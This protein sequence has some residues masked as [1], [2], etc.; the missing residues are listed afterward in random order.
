MRFR[1]DM[2]VKL[3]ACYGSDELIA[4]A[5]RVSTDGAGSLANRPKRRL[6]DRLLRRRVQVARR[7]GGIFGLINYLLKHRHGSPFEHNGM[8]F[9][10]EAPIFV[11]RELMRHRIGVSYN[12]TSAR[13]RDLE[14]VFYVPAGERGLVRTTSTA[15]PEFASGSA[16]QRLTTWLTHHLAY[17]LAWWAY[18]LMRVL[19]VASEVARAV[20]PVGIYSSAYV[21]LNARSLMS[22]LSLR[23]HD[24]AAQF[25]SYPQA[26]IEWLARGLEAHF[27]ELFP[28]TYEAFVANGRVAP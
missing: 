20:L 7:E 10:T 11:Y 3:V 15:R 5:A 21:T 4:D 2:T 22:I 14:P 16:W 6:R 17:R 12:E 26:E 18:R 28:A 1:S 24:K 13:Y 19:G 9:Y 8:T 23:T 25:V 27:R